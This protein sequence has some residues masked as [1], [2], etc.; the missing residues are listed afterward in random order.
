MTA[1]NK[2]WKRI[3]LGLISIGL[4]LVLLVSGVVPQVAQ[5]GPGRA[6]KIGLHGVFTGGLADVGVPWSEG[7]LDYVR[8]LN[9]KQ[10]GIDGVIVKAEWE[11][12]RALIPRTLTAHKRFMEKGVVAELII[13]SGP[14]EA[15]RPFA[16]RDEVPV[17]YV[18]GPTRS[19]F[20]PRPRWEFGMCFQVETWLAMP[21]WWF[22]EEVWT[23]ERPPRVGLMIFDVAAVRD[24]IE[25][26]EYFADELGYELIGYEVVPFYGAIDTSVEWLRLLAK[27]PDIVIVGV[28]ASS[29]VTLAK[30]AG[31][32][33]IIEKG[34][35]I[36]A[37]TLA[38][39]QSM[40]DIIGKEAENWYSLNPYPT[41][42]DTHLPG[43]K[44]IYEAAKEYRDR[45]PRD[46]AGYYIAG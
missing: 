21:A 17:I 10:G 29:L 14:G 32:L 6:V 37:T 19:M 44:F 4:V 11:D 12:T 41:S 39:L 22:A 38:L 3:G 20:T 18:G 40:V 5:A 45:E 35:P 16:I 28:Y 8:Y 13:E 31:R 24:A 2:A 43:M 34:T 42:V 15:L 36:C 27:K 25:G 30:D 46:I 7:V 26:A 1:V 33:E 23:E 9:E